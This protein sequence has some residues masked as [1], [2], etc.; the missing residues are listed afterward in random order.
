MLR[1]EPLFRV[2]IEDAGDQVESVKFGV[3]SGIFGVVPGKFRSGQAC[4]GT[5]LLMIGARSATTGIFVKVE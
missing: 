3:E 1:K 2:S 5:E 4:S